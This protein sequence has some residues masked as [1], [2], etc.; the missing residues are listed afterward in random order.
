MLK[1]IKHVTEHHS[2]L[3]GG[4]KGCFDRDIVSVVNV[5]LST[6]T[7]TRTID[8]VGETFMLF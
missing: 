2:T 4:G 8:V 1:Y 3:I 5:R 7:M 6:L